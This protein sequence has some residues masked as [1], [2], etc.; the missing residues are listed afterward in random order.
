MAFSYTT[1][2]P[3][4]AIADTNVIYA[5]HVTDVYSR[6]DTMATW[7]TSQMAGKL[8]F[9]TPVLTEASVRFTPGSVDPTTLESGDMW[10]NNGVLKFRSGSTTQTVAFTG[11]GGSF[12]TL[13][14]SGATTLAGTTATTLTATGVT[15]L[16]NQAFVSTTNAQAFVA[17][18]VSAGTEV[19]RVDTT[20]DRVEVRTGSTFRVMDATNALA[21]FTVSGS[22]AVTAAS[23]SA[24]GAISGASLA[25]TGAVSSGGTAYV[26][27]ANVN[28]G[29]F[30]INLGNGVQ[31]I[32]VGAQLPAVTIPYKCEPEHIYITTNG[33]GSTNTT[34]VAITVQ[35]QRRAV[36]T[37]NSYADIGS[38]LTLSSS[39][40]ISQANAAFTAGITLNPGDTLR[41]VTS[42]T[43]TAQAVAVHVR[44][45][46]KD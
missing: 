1:L 10:N 42:G 12:T 41:V 11:A 39:A 18:K 21:N 6:V 7:F 23:V 5:S 9:F 37:N 13:T 30:T 31:A 32:T 14:A 27:P 22:G 4:A 29:G 15:N 16:N 33:T 20:N 36:G 2:L 8:K 38:P 44:V 19:F 46:R 43:I 34:S 26:S 25:V 40:T 28:T 24:T 17:R 45:K 3:N 35:I